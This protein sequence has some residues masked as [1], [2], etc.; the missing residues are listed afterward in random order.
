[1]IFCWLYVN[2][3]CIFLVQSIVC[4]T[5]EHLLLMILV[6]ELVMIPAMK[7]EMKVNGYIL[8][9]MLCAMRIV[10][11][12][13]LKFYEVVAC[14]LFDTVGGNFSKVWFCAT[15]FGMSEWN[16]NANKNSLM[17]VVMEWSYIGCVK[18]TTALQINF[19]WMASWKYN[20]YTTARTLIS[21]RWYVL[22]AH[23]MNVIVTIRY[24]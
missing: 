3:E 7:N 16:I 4:G 21:R 2:C 10:D 5:N 24:H 18:A 15:W 8:L 19:N 6:W 20:I 1:M 14:L 9:H 12:W 22:N 23:P 13:I 11:G 17:C